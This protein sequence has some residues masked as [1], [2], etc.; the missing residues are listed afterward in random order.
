[1]F[2]LS[3]ILIC[4]WKTINFPIIRTLVTAH[5]FW[6]IISLL[7]FSLTYYKISIVISS[8]RHGLFRS[9][10]FY[11][12]LAFCNV[13]VMIREQNLHDFSPLKFV[14]TCFV[15]WLIE[16]CGNCSA[17]TP[18]KCYCEAFGYSLLSLSI[19]SSWFIG[20]STLQY[21][22]WFYCLPVLQGVLNSPTMIEARSIFPL[23]SFRTLDFL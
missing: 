19:W 14:E 22:Y 18:R 5:K 3:S 2:S 8:K 10:L 4:T 21:L 15:H 17:G 6:Y 1:M 23:S 12:S 20:C 9:V 16:Y 13:L 11:F 7:R